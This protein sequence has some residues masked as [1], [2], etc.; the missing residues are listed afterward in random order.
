MLSYV[1]Y[2][3]RHYRTQLIKLAASLASSLACGLSKLVVATSLLLMKTCT[4]M[5]HMP[6]GGSWEML[7]SIPA[8]CICNPLLSSCGNNSISQAFYVSLGSGT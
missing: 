2:S 5:S 7:S 1:Q 8:H 3:S 4:L 6:V